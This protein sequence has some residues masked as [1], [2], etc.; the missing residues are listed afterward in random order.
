MGYKWGMT[1]SKKISAYSKCL[2][3]V[4]SL[5]LL[6]T[7]SLSSE[8]G[9]DAFCKKV[10][11]FN[12]TEKQKLQF[13]KILKD[14]EFNLRVSFK[15]QDSVIKHAPI[16]KNSRN[17]LLLSLGEKVADLVVLA[18]YFISEQGKQS[19]F[20]EVFSSYLYFKG[21]D[22]SKGNIIMAEFPLY[23]FDINQGYHALP[24]VLVNRKSLELYKKYLM[25]RLENLITHA[26]DFK[27]K[28]DFPSHLQA[29]VFS[30]EINFVKILDQIFIMEPGLESI[31]LGISKQYTKIVEKKGLREKSIELMNPTEFSNFVRNVEDNIFDPV[32]SNFE[33]RPYYNILLMQKKFHDLVGEFL[34]IKKIPEEDLPTKVS[35]WYR[36]IKRRFKGQDEQENLANYV[37]KFQNNF[38][39]DTQAEAFLYSISGRSYVWDEF[40]MR[41]GSYANSMIKIE[42]TEFL[43]KK[44]FGQLELLRSAELLR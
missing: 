25:I 8:F 20:E 44:A 40:N 30:S 14:T 39:L 27:N 23:V 3:L 24:N 38:K 31:S 4:L 26:N 7:I 2:A 19:R 34:R 1:K 29:S 10:F 13:E 36:K 11:S 37:E 41:F 5:Q 28:K 9:S 22:E 6:S 18:P 33:L 42:F 35:E 15:H 17:T 16:M 12:L 21:L 32:K 43:T